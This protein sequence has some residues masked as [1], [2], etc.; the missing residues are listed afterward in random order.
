MLPKSTCCKTWLKIVETNYH[1]ASV[2]IAECTRCNKSFYYPYQK[3]YEQPEP[4]GEGE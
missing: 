1:G 4:F 2:D 3:I